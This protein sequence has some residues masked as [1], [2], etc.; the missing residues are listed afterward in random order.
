M[1]NDERLLG[2]ANKPRRD[3]LGFQDK[4]L[5]EWMALLIVPF[6]WYDHSIVNKF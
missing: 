5:W 3:W 6:F 4:A 2:R 1:D